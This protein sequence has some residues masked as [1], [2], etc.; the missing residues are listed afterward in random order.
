MI[1]WRL[2]SAREK[3]RATINLRGEYADHTD[4]DVL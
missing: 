1:A 2:F 4:E 3:S